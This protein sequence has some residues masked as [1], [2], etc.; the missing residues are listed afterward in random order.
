MPQA[1]Q[2][3]P[4]YGRDYSSKGEAIKDWKDGK[5]F[6]IPSPFIQGRYINKQDAERFSVHSVII[7]YNKTRNSVKVK[8]EG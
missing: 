7:R 2:I 4:A 5:D 6:K 8:V 3:L 1:I